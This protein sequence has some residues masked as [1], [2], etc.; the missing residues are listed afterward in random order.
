[1]DFNFFK[2]CNYNNLKEK[3][4]LALVD[5]NFSSS[6]IFIKPNLG[7]RYPI[8][9]GENTD[10]IFLKILLEELLNKKARKIIIGHGDLLGVPQ[11][12]FPFEKIIKEGGFSFLREIKKVDLINIDKGKR[13]KIECEGFTFSLPTILEESDFYINLAKVKT[14]METSVTLS[15]KNQMGLL[16]QEERIRMHQ[17]SLEDL[18]SL[19]AKVARPD[20]SIID[21]LKAMEGNGPHHGKTKELGIVAAG[22]DMVKLDSVVSFYSGFDFR[23]IKH[24]SQARELGVGEYPSKKEL[25]EI[26]ALGVE[27]L[28]KAEKYYKFGKNIYVW[29]TTACSRCITALNESGKIIKKRPIANR[30]FIRKAFSGKEKIN[31]VIGKA[32]NLDLPKDEKCITIGRCTECFSKRKNI[33]N[34]DMCPPTT[35][36]TLQHIKKKIEDD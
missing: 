3:I 4:N 7:G 26:T 9:P 34:L 31:I 18:I 20:I 8:I 30:K 5:F 29:P 22:N 11:K 6:E 28:K 35:Q 33:E 1:M 23:R 12:R 10:P 14:H 16:P 2:G 24:I 25:S 13:K 15:L 36:K 17:K 19:L 27:R 21:G 32:T